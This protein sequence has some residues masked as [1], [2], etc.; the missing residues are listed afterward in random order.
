M[1]SGRRRRITRGILP[2]TNQSQGRQRGCSLLAS[3]DHSPKFAI[4]SMTLK[5]KA[6]P[7]SPDRLERR[8]DELNGKLDPLIR[9]LNGWRRIKNEC[10]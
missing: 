1:A 9:S 8:I 6:R 5:M 3:I 7:A 4:G 2:V 10:S